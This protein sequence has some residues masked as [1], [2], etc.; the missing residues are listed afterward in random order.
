MAYTLEVE[1]G[2]SGGEGAGRLRLSDAEHDALADAI[3]RSGPVARLLRRIVDPELGARFVPAEARLVLHE[4]ESLADGLDE[5]DR[6]R[7][8]VTIASLRDLVETAVRAGASV[9]AEAG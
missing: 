2:E 3:M 5:S 1:A 9:R 6:E 7:V 8:A 4:L